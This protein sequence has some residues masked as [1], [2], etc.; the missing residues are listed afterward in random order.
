MSDERRYL[1]ARLAGWLMWGLLA[2]LA[3]GAFVGC[4]VLRE[5]A[6]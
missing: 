1:M 4:M 2:L 3:S 5:Q 6:L